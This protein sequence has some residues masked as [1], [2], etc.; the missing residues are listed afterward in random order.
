MEE[1]E[2]RCSSHPPPF[3]VPYTAWPNNPGG[4]SPPP[5]CCTTWPLQP[6]K[7]PPAAPASQQ[8]LRSQRQLFLVVLLALSEGGVGPTG[9][10]F[11]VLE[12]QG[13]YWL[14]QQAPPPG[15]KHP[16]KQITPACAC[17]L[18]TTALHG[19]RPVGLNTHSHT[20]NAPSLCC[21]PSFLLSTPACVSIH[22]PHLVCLLWC[23]CCCQ[24]LSHSP[25][26]NSITS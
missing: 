2:R 13:R 21:P 6:T 12:P 19:K 18:D 26:A 16:P 5:P 25:P 3:R 10:G 7:V 14:Q 20:N 9:A 11:T 17:V 8:Q 1:R 22:H 24:A 4:V 23:G 15:D